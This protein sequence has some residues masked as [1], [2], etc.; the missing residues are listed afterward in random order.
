MSGHNKWSSIK[1]KKGAADAKR[2]QLF[3][4]LVKEI[5]LAARNGGGDP[6]ANPRLRTAILNAKAA[7]MP[8][9]NIERAIKRGTGEIEGANYEEVVYEGYGPNGIG[10]VIEVMTDNKNRTIAD[11]RHT[12]TKYGGTMA[13]SG[14]VA[15]NFEQKGFFNVP[16]AGLDED[17]FM[18][19]ALEAGAE[20]IELNGDYF[21]VYTAPQDFHTVLANMEKLGYP[22]ENAELTRVPKTTIN[23][24]DVAPKIFKLIEMLE[25]LDDVQKVYANFEVSDEVM[26]ALSQE[27]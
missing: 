27:A 13:E 4:R 1:H 8:R 16:A 9:E 12:L 2:G 15:W 22:I 14:A 18:L 25:E 17:E 3:T 10:L 23:A 24:D 5:I 7:N 20:D 21:D 11:L 19:Q 26:E 6:E